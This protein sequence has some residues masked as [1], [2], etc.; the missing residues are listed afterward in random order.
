MEKQTKLY[1]SLIGVGLVTVL[2]LLVPLVAMQFTS[3][4]DWGPADFLIIGALIFSTGLAYVLLTRGAANTVYRIAAGLALGT[5]FLLIWANLAVGLIGSGPNAGNLMY[6]AVVFVAVI[7]A[8]RARFKAAGMEFAM[9]ATAAA[10]VVLAGIA[11]SAGMQH[12]PG[13]SVSEILGVSGFFAG[14]FLV[15]GSLFRY[16]ARTAL[17][18]QAQ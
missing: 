16:A 6:M 8:I 14:L 15:A 4:V 7:G 18:K 1:P 12:Y 13:S 11:I 17:P 5:T 9:Y 3:E 10:L 2:I